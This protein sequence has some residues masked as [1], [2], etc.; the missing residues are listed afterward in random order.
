MAL[1]CVG[2]EIDIFD[3][4]RELADNCKH[5]NDVIIECTNTD[6][7]KPIEP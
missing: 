3:C 7:D 5:N 4:Y 1:K 2:N 6:F